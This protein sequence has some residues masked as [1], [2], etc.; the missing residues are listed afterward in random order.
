MYALAHMDTHSSTYLVGGDMDV[1]LNASN[2][3]FVVT[4]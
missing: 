1:G 2:V 4:C 3:L